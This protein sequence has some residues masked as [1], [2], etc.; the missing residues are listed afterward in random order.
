MNFVDRND[1]FELHQYAFS[2]VVYTGCMPE[3]SIQEFLR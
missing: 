3:F 2:V 1:F